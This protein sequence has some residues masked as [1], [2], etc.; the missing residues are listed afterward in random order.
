MFVIEVDCSQPCLLIALLACDLLRSP[1][2]KSRT[3]FKSGCCFDPPRHKFHFTYII[4]IGLVG[5]WPAQTKT[6]RRLTKSIFFVPRPPGY[7]T[8]KLREYIQ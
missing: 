3:L 7:D 5:L 1:L 2:F 6:D 4:R 8:Y